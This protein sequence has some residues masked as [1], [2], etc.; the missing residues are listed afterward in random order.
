MNK[1]GRLA[2]TLATAAALAVGGAT[3]VQ[4]APVLPSAPS[5]TTVSIQTSAAGP[6]TGIGDLFCKDGSCWIDMC[7]SFKYLHWTAEMFV[8]AAG[9]QPILSIV[10]KPIIHPLLWTPLD[11]LTGGCDADSHPPELGGGGGGGGGA[12]S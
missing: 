12:T 4:A 2:V 3:A 7:N 6:A 5:A 11:G 9:M 1:F 8:S 10:D